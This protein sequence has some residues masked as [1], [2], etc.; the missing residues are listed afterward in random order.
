[1]SQISKKIN[2]T[3]VY[4]SIYRIENQPTQ[5]CYLPLYCIR[6]DLNTTTQEKAD[7]KNKAK[8]RTRVDKVVK[9]LLNKLFVPP[10][11]KWVERQ[12]VT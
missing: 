7:T 3:G 5:N 4:C 10:M 2:R 9:I 6:G 1:M 11:G 12:N 8:Q